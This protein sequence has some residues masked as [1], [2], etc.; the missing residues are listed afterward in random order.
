MKNFVKEHWPQGVA[1]LTAALLL[2]WAAGCPAKVESPILP[3]K[4]LTG[5]EL[6]A[7]LDQLLVMYEIR[8]EQLAQQQ[9][10]R[11]LILQNAMM[12]VQ[13]Q[14]VNPVGILTGLLAFYGA[15]TAVV[16]TKKAITKRHSSTP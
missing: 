4:H 14:T 2:L 11:Q 3:G 7:E 12:M 5:R 13:T 10:L 6:Q 8:S 9:R 16:S 15:G 1:L